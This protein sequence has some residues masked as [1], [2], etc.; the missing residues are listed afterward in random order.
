MSE[1]RDGFFANI[2]DAYKQTIIL[3]VMLI[4]YLIVPAGI[5]VLG[6]WL[7]VVNQGHAWMAGFAELVNTWSLIIGNPSAIAT[8]H[9]GYY[10][11]ILAALMAIISFAAAFLFTASRND[12]IGKPLGFFK[13]F[14]SSWGILFTYVLIAAIFFGAWFGLT[15][16]NIDL[17][18]TIMFWVAVGFSALSI[19]ALIFRTVDYLLELE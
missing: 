1:E 8:I 4:A 17:L 9:W 13:A 5:A 6:Y 18:D 19:I 15:Y 10:I 12:R 3:V 11:M 16:L 14:L 2:F 7:G